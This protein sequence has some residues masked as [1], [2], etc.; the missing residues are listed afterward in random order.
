MISIETITTYVLENFSSLA[1]YRGAILIW[2]RATWYATETS[3]IDIHII[4][5]KNNPMN[6]IWDMLQWITVSV[7]IYP[8]DIVLS[9]INYAATHWSHLY[10]RMYGIQWVILDDQYDILRSIK[11]TA[12]STSII[13]TYNFSNLSLVVW[14]FKEF[15]RVWNNVSYLREKLLFYIFEQYSFY[16]WYD[17][18]N[19]FNIIFWKHAY[20]IFH[21]DDYALA[22][23]WKIYPDKTFINLWEQSYNEPQNQDFFNDLIT[24]TIM[25]LS[26]LLI[27]SW[28]FWTKKA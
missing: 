23:R 9:K 11:S 27:Q 26:E 2:S 8:I 15:Q 5:D 12:L 3:D 19:E 20:K 17:H 1:W 21:D 10:K 6:Q 18:Y 25:K 28:Y 7:R 13:Y 22:H 16:M 24:Y 4:V 14:W